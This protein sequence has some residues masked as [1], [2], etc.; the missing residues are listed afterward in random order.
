MAVAHHNP[1]IP[2]FSPD[3]SICLVDG[4]FYLVNSSFHLYPG[5][6]IYMSN[7]LVSW[8]HI[9][10]AIN[11]PSQLSLSRATTFVGPLDDGTELVATGGLYAPT[12]RHHNGITYI[13]CTNV[14]HGTSNVLGDEHSE[15]FIIHTTDIRS[16]NW[17]D[18]IVF[19]FPGI[20]PSLL[21]DDDGRVY[22]QLCKTGPEFEIYN[23][24]IDITTGK[25]IV[26]PTLIW[27][28]W[29]KGYTEGPHIYKKDGWYYLLC[30]E[31]GTF[32]YHMLS[33]ARS[34]NIWGPY[35]SY[36]MNPLY[37]AS[38]TAQYVQN[39][40]HGDL[41]QDQNGQ[42]WVVMLGV[43]MKEGRSIM[44]RETFLTSVDWP[45]DGWPTIQPITCDGDPGGNFKAEGPDS[46]AAPW[47]YLRDA[48]L[49][50][51]HMQDNRITLQ[52]D[53]VEI[54]SA[55]ESITF[56]G[57]RQRR[58]EG[59]TTV[60]VYMPQHST[61]VRAGLALYKDEH[62]FLTIGYDFHLQQVVFNGL[63]Q[64]QSFSQSETQ[65][66]ELQDFISFKIG[67]T[68]TSLQFGFRVDEAGWHD[69][70]TLDT[71]ILTDLDFTGPVIGIFAI[72]D[73][74]AVEFADFEVDAV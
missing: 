8:K 54:T 55:D 9:G 51:Y 65:N 7:D 20:D 34:R 52:A 27:T 32:Q 39:T 22:V 17:S 44:G 46:L 61:S 70:A 12:I 33:M 41:F 26:E 11:R 42:W 50:R 2:G 30:A 18:P 10:N 47:V 53:S 24:E 74:V 56:V 72:G 21:F 37:T 31:G 63:N 29:K 25:R 16:G 43:R 15:Q 13:I 38:G 58:L 69:L 19:E 48:K 28:G 60:T 57:Q 73:D 64:A 23:S 36:E 71:A 5:L 6:P 59:T 66:V 45:C 14:I 1:I 67:Y 4:I 3:P 62:R 35:R 68:E 40:G 49:D